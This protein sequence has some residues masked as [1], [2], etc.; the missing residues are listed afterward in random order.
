[1]S[2]D[3]RAYNRIL[4]FIEF[5]SLLAVALAADSV[6][7]TRRARAV[8]AVV[9]LTVGIVDQGQASQH[10][11]VEYSRIV[12]E[13]SSLEPFVRKLE[14][15]VPDGARVFQLPFRMYMNESESGLMQP[16]D[17]FKPYLVSHTL[18]FSYPA[19]S[20][21]QV[22]WQ[23]AAAGLD[24]RRLTFQLAAQR[25][26]AVLVDRYG[27]E[28]NGAA[29]TAAILRVVGDDRVIAET[30]RYV[31][32]DIRALAKASESPPV[33]MSTE[34]PATLSMDVCEGQTVVIVD[35]IG[36]NPGPFGA[37][38]PHVPGS[39]QF[40][41]RGW[42]VDYS[43]RSAA[44]GVDIVVDRTLFPSTYGGNRDDVAA[45]YHLPA[46]RQSGFAANIPAERFARGE[47]WL[48]LRVVASDGRCFYQ[49][50]EI[51]VIVE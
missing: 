44:G 13:M 36:A 2:P 19:L 40:R 33:D 26:S 10:F 17:H 22:R 6:C 3:I 23:Q 43:N 18:R 15:A 16:Y 1:V 46:Y 39:G 25:F 4:P 35:Q 34:V 50:P 32:L 24:L 29:V 31:A 27:Y 30:D 51:P 9:V 5:F 49:G 20:N 8:A 41:V 21:E 7:K 12:T 11:N 14:S 37:R 42:A 38:S 47:H 28:D 45:Q 48:S